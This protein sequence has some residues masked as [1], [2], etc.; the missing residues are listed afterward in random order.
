MQ[1][2]NLCLNGEIWRN[3][4][5]YEGLYQI[6]NMG[7][8][9]SLNRQTISSNN[10]IYHLKTKIINPSIMKCGYFYINLCKNG[11]ATPDR[12]KYHN[13]TSVKILSE[14]YKKPIRLVYKVVNEETYKYL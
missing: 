10:R 7:R 4:R 3:I 1:N 14:E 6:S 5:N 11:I 2:E 13:G 8:G 12:E 9:K